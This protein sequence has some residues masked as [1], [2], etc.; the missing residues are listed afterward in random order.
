MTKSLRVVTD[1]TSLALEAGLTR[2]G[3]VR[4][5][6]KDLESEGWLE[7][8]IGTPHTFDNGIIGKRGRPSE[9]KLVPKPHAGRYRLNRL[10]LLTLDY[11]TTERLGTAGWFVMA[12]VIF[13]ELTGQTPRLRLT[14]IVELTGM[15]LSRVKRTMKRLIPTSL[16]YKEGLDYC[17][18]N[19]YE[20]YD[21]NC[22]GDYRSEDRLHKHWEKSRKLNEFQVGMNGMKFV[23]RPIPKD[24]WDKINALIDSQP[25]T[26]VT[27]ECP[28][29][30]SQDSVGTR[31]D[32]GE[33][34]NQSRESDALAEDHVRPRI[35]DYLNF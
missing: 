35:S 24:T 29:G 13:E 7:F 3:S 16:C 17:F 34:I 21:R 11:F 19:T 6:L 23:Q 26:R 20:L 33:C 14:D 28:L 27:S 15:S 12:R 10:P 8:R 22:W 2:Y 32:T 4:D 18:Y 9:I 30:Q 25:S 5:A 1:L 31:Q